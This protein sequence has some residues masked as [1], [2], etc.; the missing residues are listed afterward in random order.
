MNCVDYGAS[1]TLKLNEMRGL[2]E[3]KVKEVTT[4]CIKYMGTLCR[5]FVKRLSANL[6]LFERLRYQTPEEC[7]KKYPHRP[8]FFSLPLDMRGILF[9]TFA[10]AVSVVETKKVLLAFFYF[11][12]RKVTLTV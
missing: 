6:H 11:Q 2:P 4:R 12:I 10:K 8:D 5:E 9:L 7:L 3:D 1:F